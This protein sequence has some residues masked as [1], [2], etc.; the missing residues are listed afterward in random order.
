MITDTSP[1]AAPN[2]SETHSVIRNARGPRK[3]NSG[4][5]AYQLR[6]RQSRAKLEAGLEKDWRHVDGERLTPALWQ[7]PGP[8]CAL[9]EPPMQPRMASLRPVT[10]PWPVRSPPRAGANRA[11]SQVYVALSVQVHWLSAI[12]LL[13]CVDA[14]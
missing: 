12:Q 4:M 7:P 6:H 9:H 3:A 14:S 8:V 2:H 1:G 11:C 13:A 5:G 10:P